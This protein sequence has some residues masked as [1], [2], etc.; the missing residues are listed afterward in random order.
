MEGAVPSAWTDSE[1]PPRERHQAE[2]SAGG[3]G[4][5]RQ[6]GGSHAAWSARQAA[7]RL[8]SPAAL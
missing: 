7:A 6:R 8:E 3:E 1:V 4:G 5:L 2:E